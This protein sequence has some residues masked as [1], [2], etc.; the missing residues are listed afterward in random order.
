M[1]LTNGKL[2]PIP[3]TLD[4]SD[5]ILS[6]IDNK[7]KIALK[8]KEGFTIAILRITDIWQPNLLKEAKLVYDTNHLSHPAVN[9]LLNVGFKNY[10]GGVVQ[11]ISLPKHYD[12]KKYRHTP[13]EL[14]S[15]FKKK[16]LNK[17]IAF[18]TRNPLHKAHVE[19]TLRAIKEHNAKLLIHPAVGMTKP[20]DVDHYTRVRCYQHV[21]K[22]Y[23]NDSTILS[24]CCRLL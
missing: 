3:I 4:V 24:I 22:K 9:Y 5:S 8:D 23:P 15:I 19:M 11:G 10:I 6:K 20:G 13:K 16:K 21:L 14:H 2:W 7:E 1:R 17:V 12:F 18:Q